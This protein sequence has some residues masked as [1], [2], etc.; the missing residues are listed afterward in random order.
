MAR[1]SANAIVGLLSGKLG[2][3]VFVQRRDGALFVRERVEPRNPRT[4]AQRAWRGLVGRAA[5][6]F[7]A[8]TPEQYALWVDYCR[9]LDAQNAAEG[10]PGCARPINVFTS[11][12]AKFLQA[13]PGAVPPTTPPGSPFQGDGV[14]VSAGAG[15]GTV[16]FASN[17]PNA[18]DV[19]TE[20][21][22]QRVASINGAPTPRGYRTSGYHA[23]APGSL[24]ASVSAEPGFYAAAVRFVRTTTGQS[25][26]VVALGNLKVA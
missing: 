16:A 10:R 2:N 7:K 18:P 11:L 12:T 8:L 21:L 9:D 3:V 25:S 6:E 20:L 4:P 15:E 5:K 22:L 1:A 13:T 23:F 24:S 19:A 17:A 14:S 26:G